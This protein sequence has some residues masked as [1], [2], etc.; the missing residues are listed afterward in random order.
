MHVQL[1]KLQGIFMVVEDFTKNIWLSK[2]LVNDV[3]FAKF[4]KVS[5]RQNFELYGMLLT[6]YTT[7]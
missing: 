6:L 4:A 2:I 3:Q 1:S 7:R 5:P